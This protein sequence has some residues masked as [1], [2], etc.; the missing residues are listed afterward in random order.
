MLRID[1][2]GI[3]QLGQEL[4]IYLT[5]K[6]IIYRMGKD[7]R[8]SEGVAKGFGYSEPCFE[9]P[10]HKLNVISLIYGLPVAKPFSGSSAQILETGT[11]MPGFPGLVSALGG[12]VPVSTKGDRVICPVR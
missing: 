10:A 11:V 12:R 9:N 2:V 7:S 5:P 4:R 6:S 3:S 1:R 8:V